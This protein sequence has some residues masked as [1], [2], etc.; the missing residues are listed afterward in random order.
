MPGVFRAA[1]VLPIAQ[2]PIR[3]GW[4]AV[5]R[6][7]I[8]A[9][10]GPEDD[11]P[12][13]ATD[14]AERSGAS[15]HADGTAAQVAVLP[16]LVNAHTHLEISWMRGQVKPAESMPAWV[17]RLMA[18]RRT[19][20]SEPP[21][22]I[23]D[24][25]AETRAAGTTLVGEVTN[26]LSAYD[27]LL[28]SD[29]SAAIFRELLGFNVTDDAR[30][31]V[32]ETQAAIDALTP[33]ERLR[34]SIV[35]HAPYSVSAPLFR[36]IAAAAGD[37]KV[38]VHLAE[39]IE[40]LQFLKDG[41]G[42]WRTLI[43]RLGLWN[44]GWTAPGVGPVAYLQQFGLVNDRLIAVHG[45]QLTDEELARLAAAG[46]T[47]VTCPRS[48]IWTGAGEPPI[49]RFYASGVRVAIGTDSLASVDDLNVFQELAAARRLAP[50]VRAARLLE[51]ATRAGAEALG[52]GGDLG[53][54][55][56]G[57]RAELIAVRVPPGLEDVEQYLVSGI[58]PEDIAWVGD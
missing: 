20:G 49:E 29:L 11:P 50:R 26:T 13:A 17:E 53:T 6:G 39:P 33:V 25:I 9:V 40:E 14:A 48:N 2:P 19:V 45:V 28:E 16:G 42:A 12:V 55:E 46:A 51:S 1:W 5:D 15:R 32:A 24:A 10:G 37:R 44:P 3:D 30:R 41:T 57:K 36:A 8:V 47:V 4:V 34:P 38:S 7:R 18:L 35:P 21:E 23:S 22:P 58:K 43:D 31:L 27:A 54:I 52:F 56:P